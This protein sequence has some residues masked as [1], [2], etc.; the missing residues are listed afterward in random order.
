MKTTGAGTSCEMSCQWSFAT[1]LVIM[2]AGRKQSPLPFSVSTYSVNRDWSCWHK[3]TRQDSVVWPVAWEEVPV[4]TDNMSVWCFA[5]GHRCFIIHVTSLLVPDLW[6]HIDAAR[7]QSKNTGCD[8]M[9]ATVVLNLD[10]LWCPVEA[11]FFSIGKEYKDISQMFS[12]RWKWCSMIGR[13]RFLL[14]SY[15]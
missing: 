15:I 11:V 14:M 2:S 4:H 5:T 7:H 6:F 12:L 9:I 3:R 1:P 10:L 13:R 8:S